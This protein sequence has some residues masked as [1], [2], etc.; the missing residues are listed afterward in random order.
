MVAL[1]LSQEMLS[2]H[3]LSETTLCT[4]NREANSKQGSNER[5]VET[6]PDTTTEGVIVIDG[7]LSGLVRLGR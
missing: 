3:L 1:A 2:H 6:V 7:I 4:H 5:M